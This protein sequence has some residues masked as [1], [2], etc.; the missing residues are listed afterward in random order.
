[1]L[2]R[3]SRPSPL[4]RV[5]RPGQCLDLPPQ[6]IVYRLQAERDQRLDQGDVYA[7][8]LSQRAGLPAADKFP[9][10]LCIDS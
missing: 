7:Q 1:L 10:A 8:I 9:L 2:H 4:A 5:P 3:T 6:H